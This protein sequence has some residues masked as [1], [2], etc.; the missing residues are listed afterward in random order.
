M[1]PTGQAPGYPGVG[2]PDP[3]NAQRVDVLEL[4]LSAQGTN[5]IRPGWKPVASGLIEPVDMSKVPR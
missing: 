2:G 5:T 3:L 1:R 4:V